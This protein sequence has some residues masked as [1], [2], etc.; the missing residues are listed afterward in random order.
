MLL[1]K[2]ARFAAPLVLLFALCAH[3]QNGATALPDAPTPAPQPENNAVT[4]RNTPRNILE[5][6]KAIWTS[7]ARIRESNA[8][9]PA[10]LVLATTVLITTDHQVMSSSGLIDPSLNSDA[11]TASNGLLGGFV[12]TPVLIYGMGHIHHD[13]YATQTGI[14]GGEA[15]VNS[16]VV[17]QVM[18]FISLRERPTVDGARG[19]FFQTSVGTDSS[20]PST[21]CMIAWSSAAVIASQYNG[22]LTKIT[23]YSLA[24]GLSVT[25]VLA[26]QHFPSDVLVGSAVGWM[27]GRYVAHRHHRE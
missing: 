21:H 2:P 20:F 13:D 25:R 26:R 23:A 1:Q 10:I 8:A 3:A 12:A 24:T 11:S 27:I 17:D 6:Q 15:M 4:L 7:P 14:L 9:G 22:P 19:R 16:L 5:D 18:K